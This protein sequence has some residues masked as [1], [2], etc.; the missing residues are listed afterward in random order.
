[1]SS[2][3]YLELLVSRY[4]QLCWINRNN[5]LY[6]L[7]HRRLPVKSKGYRYTKMCTTAES[8]LSSA[9]SPA[10]KP[11]LEEDASKVEHAKLLL[12]VATIVA[13]MDNSFMF[14]NNYFLRSR[15]LLVCALLVRA[16][17]R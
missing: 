5:R 12:N 10:I 3:Q 4:C 13:V 7:P 14:F 1:M 16:S 9:P 8:P 15:I 17:S 2:H 6:L 11:E